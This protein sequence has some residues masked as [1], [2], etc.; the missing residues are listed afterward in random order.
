V[1]T[2]VAWPIVSGRLPGHECGYA[3]FGA[4]VHAGLVFHG[5]PDTIVLPPQRFV[6]IRCPEERA[7]RLAGSGIGSLAVAETFV[8]LGPPVVRPLVPSPSLIARC[9]VIR[10]TEHGSRVTAELLAEG[11]RKQ[12]DRMGLVSRYR[13]RVGGR[14]VIR[15]AGK[16]IPGYGLS[17]DNLT[18]RDSLIVQSRGVG[19]RIR[20]GCGG[21]VPC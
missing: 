6:V 12:L 2:E 1:L 10:S 8:R 9:V 15:V 19:G 14:R 11:A 13:L 7:W 20:M 16:T 17:I 18:D 4:L 21:F 3:L 5:Q